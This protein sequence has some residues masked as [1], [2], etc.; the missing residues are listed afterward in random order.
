[1]SSLFLLS[2]LVKIGTL[3]KALKKIELQIVIKDNMTGSVDI[4][5]C[6]FEK[7]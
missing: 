3:I 6:I 7:N 2:A 5:R 1:M 4:L